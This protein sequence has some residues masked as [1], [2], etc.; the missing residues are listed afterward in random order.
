MN[1]AD[2]QFW[3]ANVN[4]FHT[5]SNKITASARVLIFNGNTLNF[6]HIFLIKNAMLIK[7]NN[8]KMYKVQNKIVA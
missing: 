6:F 5:L 7:L 1:C 8:T 3:F 4:N 2:E